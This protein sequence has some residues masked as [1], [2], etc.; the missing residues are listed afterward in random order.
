MP[1]GGWVVIVNAPPIER[2][3][4]DL[5]VARLHPQFIPVGVH[6]CAA[7]PT[8]EHRPKIDLVVE[9]KVAFRSGKILWRI[10]C[11]IGRDGIQDNTH[12][13]V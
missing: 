6:E 8:C 7:I 10:A 4:R 11:R 1:D 13:D 5:H 3:V 9:L 12:L 2:L